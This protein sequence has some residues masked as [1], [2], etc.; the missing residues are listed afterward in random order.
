[1]AGIVNGV[2]KTQKE[3]RA[4]EG[5][6]HCLATPLGYWDL[7]HLFLL[8]S[9]RKCSSKLSPR[10]KKGKHLSVYFHYIG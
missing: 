10:N 1:M 3:Q 7:K 8:R 4:K 6:I 5:I 2:N 9:L